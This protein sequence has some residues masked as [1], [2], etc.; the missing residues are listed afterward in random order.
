MSRPI[1]SRAT[2]RAVS[3]VYFTDAPLSEM[4]RYLEID[5]A[6]RNLVCIPFPDVRFGKIV[7]LWQ[8]LLVGEVRILHIPDEIIAA[9]K[10][11]EFE[12]EDV[13]DVNAELGPRANDVDRFRQTHI[14]LIEVEPSHVVRFGRHVPG[15]VICELIPLSPPEIHV[16]INVAQRTDP[17]ELRSL[18]R[19]DVQSRPALHALETAPRPPALS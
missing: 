6:G 15:S 12:V 17:K 13:L 11:E 19:S 2:C 7:G 16:H 14:Y 3:L 8:T 5:Y 9:E 4:H 10:T 18:A 1:I